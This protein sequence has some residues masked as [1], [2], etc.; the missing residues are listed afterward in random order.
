VP[1]N[2]RYAEWIRQVE[3]LHD[4]LAGSDLEWF[5]LF[6]AS[7]QNSFEAQLQREAVCFAP[8]G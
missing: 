8:S 3:R 6:N 5:Q 7:L 1:Y 4:A 2:R